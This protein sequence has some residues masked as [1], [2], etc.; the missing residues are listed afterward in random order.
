[1]REKAMRHP[2]L[3]AALVLLALAGLG[4]GGWLAYEALRRPPDVQN[5]NAPFQKP[6]PQQ[7]RIV[8]TNWPI[9]GYNRARTRYLPAKGVKPPFRKVWDYSRKPLLEFPP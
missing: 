9:F 5:A 4:L 7:P 1:M 2:R 6:K 3:T 8:R